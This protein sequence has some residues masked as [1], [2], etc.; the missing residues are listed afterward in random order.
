MRRSKLITKISP[1]RSRSSAIPGP[2]DWR[3][4][5]S[6]S[7]Q[8]SAVI[9]LRQGLS[10]RPALV[11]H[12]SLNLTEEDAGSCRG[13]KREAGGGADVTAGR[14]WAHH[15]QGGGWASHRE[16]GHFG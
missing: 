6:Y 8:S 16:L 15:L 3:G 11:P 1:G 14:Q 10:A 13:A 5:P 9:R 7:S 2:I 12:V 4:K